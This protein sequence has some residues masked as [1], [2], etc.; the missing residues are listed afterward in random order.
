[1]TR[2]QST[3]SHSGE[4]H[5][6]QVA[7]CFVHKHKK[8]NGIKTTICGQC[9]VLNPSMITFSSDFLHRQ[10]PF[11]KL[12]PSSFN[13]LSFTI[14]FYDTKTAWAQQSPLNSLTMSQTPA[15]KE[16]SYPPL[17]HLELESLLLQ[18]L[19][20]GIIDLQQA[21]CLVSPTQILN[22]INFYI[23]LNYHKTLSKHMFY[24]LNIS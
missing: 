22:T 9:Q 5:L 7:L 6:P 13:L 1:M 17:L 4:I 8:I 23:L 14:F 3:G 16:H 24:S 12:P 11:A 2:V 10:K 15:N 21:P 20:P 18:I 19:K